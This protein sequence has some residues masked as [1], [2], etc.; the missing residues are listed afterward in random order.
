VFAL[1]Q[2]E[3]TKLFPSPVVHLHSTDFEELVELPAHEK[4]VRVVGI[5]QVGMGRQITRGLQRQDN[6]REDRRFRKVLTLSHATT[7]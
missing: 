7:S 6:R 3:A 2:V 1:A 5:L 4:E